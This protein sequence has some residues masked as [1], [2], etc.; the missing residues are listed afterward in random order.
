MGTKTGAL[1][2][3]REQMNDYFVGKGDTVDNVLCCFLAGGHVL[4]E[5]VPGVG[6]TTLARTFA[7]SLGLSFG[8]IQFTPDT[9]PGDVT[10]M[11]VYD[12]KKGEFNYRPGGV[13]KNIVLADELNRTSPKTQSALL[14]AMAES[15][16]TVDG[17]A[18][19]LPQPFMVI[20]TQNPINFSGTYP[21]P[22]AQ[23]D[24]FM[25]RLSVGY[26]SAEEELRLARDNMSGRKIEDV[27]AVLNAED[28]TGFREEVSK[29]HVSDGVL[30]YVQQIVAA[31][32]TDSGFSLG[33]SPRALLH[34]LQA[35][36][37]KAFLEGRSFVKPDDVKKMAVPVLSHRLILSTQMRLQ[38]KTSKDVLES[39]V[40]KVNIP[41]EADYEK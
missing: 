6:K 38:K 18:Y 30:G 13:M 36:R 40:L 35:S 29:I 21:L 37:A 25:M 11:S 28:V 15:Q 31:T 14:E 9:M 24:R 19:Q 23:L 1:Y 8:R 17:Q 7:G 16:V 32:R 34:L 3:F 12:M 27:K 5:D 41:M 4:L 10:G 26:P 33:A 22:E 20:A 39:L 2:A